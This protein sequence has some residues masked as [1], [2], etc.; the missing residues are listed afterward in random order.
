MTFQPSG[1]PSP[2][3]SLGST[4]FVVD[5][6]DLVDRRG[7]VGRRHLRERAR[8]IAAREVEVD[9]ERAAGPAGLRL[10]DRLAGGRSA[11]RRLRLRQQAEVDERLARVDRE[12]L[13]PEAVIGRDE[14]RR[15][16]AGEGAGRRQ[17]RVGALVGALDERLALGDAA[18]GRAVG[19]D[20]V[21][22]GVVRAVRQLRRD[23]AEELVLELVGRREPGHQ[24]VGVVLVHHVRQH[25]DVAG[26]PVEALLDV[27]LLADDARLEDGE[28]GR[29][30]GRERL[31]EVLREVAG[32]A[33]LAGPR[34]PGRDRAA[35]RRVEQADLREVRGQLLDL[36]E[37]ARGLAV[38]CP[39]DDL[40]LD[41]GE[42]T[43]GQGRDRVGRG[44]S[45]AR[46][47]P[48]RSSWS[49]RSCCRRSRR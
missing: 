41:V 35:D 5:G 22:G 16:A 38:E 9:L 42:L 8:G 43:L 28:V 33:G 1:L 2:V 6:A 26:L 7:Q 48:C 27:G 19:L 13:R 46:T 29:G 14:R 24:E 12:E 3:Q 20:V 23:E 10:A 34:G 4:R 11:V 31:G 15:V 32:E 25:R 21:V 47:G 30:R 40:H 18:V 45:C 39:A 49:R 44:S 17:R 37:H 36:H